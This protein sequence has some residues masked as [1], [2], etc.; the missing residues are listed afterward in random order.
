MTTFDTLNRSGLAMLATPYAIDHAEWANDPAKLD[1]CNAWV[2]HAKPIIAA[3]L[4]LDDEVDYVLLSAKIKAR[5]D[6]RWNEPTTL[7]ER[8]YSEARDVVGKAKRELRDLIEG[9]RD[10][11][12]C[13][14]RVGVQDDDAAQEEADAFN[15]WL[16]DETTSVD[17]ALDAVAQDRFDA[18]HGVR[19]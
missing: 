13:D 16:T 14:E 2:D 17:K 7:A 5:G 3:Y 18:R 9:I 10:N 11:F 19:S 15:D 4:M 8:D 1:A 12:L 6:R